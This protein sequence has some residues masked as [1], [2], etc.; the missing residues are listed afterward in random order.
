MHEDQ[1]PRLH[2]WVATGIDAMHL[3]FSMSLLIYFEVQEH[4]QCTLKVQ[5]TKI[6]YTKIKRSH[7]D[8]V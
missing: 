6:K 1:E 7:T 4:V 2:W 5:C 8:R 3:H